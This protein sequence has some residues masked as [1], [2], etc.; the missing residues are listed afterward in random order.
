M[1]FITDSFTHH[2]YSETCRRPLGD[3]RDGWRLIFQREAGQYLIN[4]QRADGGKSPQ[5]ADEE[6]TRTASPRPRYVG[7][8]AIKGS[9]Q[10]RISALV[11]FIPMLLCSSLPSLAFQPPNSVAEDRLCRAQDPH[12]VRIAESAGRGLVYSGSMPKWR[13]AALIAPRLSAGHS[14]RGERPSTDDRRPWI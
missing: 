11:T 2:S 9:G 1:R 14:C 5:V 3:C 7:L 13:N 8:D 4:A 6:A 12:P 10:S